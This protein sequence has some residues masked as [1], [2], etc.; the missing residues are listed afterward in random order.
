MHTPLKP[1]DPE[2]IPQKPSPIDA[3]INILSGPMTKQ[4]KILLGGF[5]I[6]ALI[7]TVSSFWIGF[8]DRGSDT[9]SPTPTP[10]NQSPTPTDSGDSTPITP[11]T[12]IDAGSMDITL[13]PTVTSTP[14]NTPTPTPG[15][16]NT[17]TPTN[18]PFTVTGVS[19]NAVSPSSDTQTCHTVFTFSGNINVNGS[20]EIE[21]H[22]EQNNVSQSPQTLTF[23]SNLNQQTVQI[24]WTTDVAATG[25]MVLHVTYPNNI[26]SSQ[27]SYNDH[28]TQ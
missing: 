5:I 7:V 17:P 24:Q 13:T 25:S 2:P 3:F 11:G 23:P 9:T 20:G 15:P 1:F 27:V 26:S 4:K 28:C 6:F 10:T 19:M 8:H 12:A 22:W 21:Y 14:T 18:T 16:T